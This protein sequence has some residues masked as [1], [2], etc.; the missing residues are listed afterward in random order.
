MLRPHLRQ[1]TLSIAGLILVTAFASW[2]GA[3]SGPQDPAPQAV[4]GRGED[5]APDPTAVKGW[6]LAPEWSPLLGTWGLMNFAHPAEVFESGSVGGYISISNGF[7]SLIIHARP[8]VG[9]NKTAMPDHLAQAGLH[10]WRMSEVGAPNLMQLASVMAHSN[11]GYELQWERPNEP[12]EFLVELDGDTMTLTR[13]DYSVL[14]FRRI[15]NAG[16]PESA[17]E[18]MRESRAGG[19]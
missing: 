14:T 6:A 15:T 19:D 17:L 13:A 4:D 12:R 9:E 16:F 7:L 5:P 8:M 1:T 2:S 11:F 18:R 10:R 3:P